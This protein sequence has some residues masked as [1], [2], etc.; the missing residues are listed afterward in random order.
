MQQISSPQMT[1]TKTT[2]TTT[3][4]R[5]HQQ[6]HL[7]QPQPLQTHQPQ[8]QQQRPPTRDVVQ[9]VVQSAQ[10]GFFDSSDNDTSNHPHEDEDTS[11]SS[12][13]VVSRPPSLSAASLT[14]MPRAPAMFMMSVHCDES[15]ATA[16]PPSLPSPLQQQQ[17]QQPTAPTP[18]QQHHHHR[19]QRRESFRPP[20]LSPVTPITPMASCRMPMCMEQH[21]QGA[22]T[23]GSRFCRW[24]VEAYSKYFEVGFDTV[25]EEDDDDDD[26]NTILGTA[27]TSATTTPRHRQQ[28]QHHHYWND[29]GTDSSDATR[30]STMS[31]MTM[32]LQSHLDLTAARRSRSVFVRHHRRDLPADTSKELT[33]LAVLLVMVFIVCVQRA[34]SPLYSD[35]RR[36][37]CDWTDGMCLP[38]MLDVALVVY[39]V[40][41]LG[42]VV[43]WRRRERVVLGRV[44]WYGT[45]IVVGS[46]H[47]WFMAYYLGPQT[48][49]HEMLPL[50]GVILCMFM[51]VPAYVWCSITLAV[52][53]GIV[54]RA[55]GQA[56]GSVEDALFSVWRDGASSP[57][58]T[59]R[60]FT[61]IFW[62]ELYYIVVVVTFAFVTSVVKKTHAN[63]ARTLLHIEGAAVYAHRLELDTAARF[64]ESAI[65]AADEQ[66]AKEVHVDT[67]LRVRDVFVRVAP[68]VAFVPHSVHR[69]AALNDTKKPAW[70]DE[71]ESEDDTSHFRDLKDV[72]GSEL[73]SARAM[74]SY[75][76]EGNDSSR[77]SLDEGLASSICSST[78]VGS[79]KGRRRV[80]LRQGAALRGA[81]PGVDGTLNHS[82]SGHSLNNNN[83]NMNIQL[84]STPRS[85]GPLLPPTP[86]K[87]F[88]AF[89]LGGGLAPHQRPIVSSEPIPT[90]FVQLKPGFRP[91]L[92][93]ALQTN[94]LSGPC[95]MA[96]DGDVGIV[97]PTPFINTI[98]LL[99]AR[100]R[101][102]V[103][104]YHA[105][106]LLATWT[107]SK[108]ITN[109]CEI[110]C[111]AAIDIVRSTDLPPSTLRIG[112]DRSHIVS[113]TVG[114]PQL[115]MFRELRGP[116]VEGA[117]ALTALCEQLD[118]SILISEEV[119]RLLDSA[120]GA[121]AAGHAGGLGTQVSMQSSP[122]P[123]TPQSI[124]AS[125]TGTMAL[126]A[127]GPMCLSIT[128]TAD[129]IAGV[130][131]AVA[132]CSAGSVSR[133]WIGYTT[134][135]DVAAT[136]PPR[137]GYSGVAIHDV[138]LESTSFGSA[139]AQ[140]AEWSFERG[141][142][143]FCS[144]NI[145]GARDAFCEVLVRDPTDRVAKAY[146]RT[147]S[148]LEG[149]VPPRSPRVVGGDGDGLPE[150]R[151]IDLAAT[152]MSVMEYD[153]D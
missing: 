18:K 127:V 71:G 109:P 118:T 11:S 56:W 49:R 50:A 92:A 89:A 26:D 95:G 51:Q 33:H 31:S 19:H 75:V 128:S 132:G 77:M 46:L 22:P 70:E 103:H 86:S 74:S 6:Q 25:G 137:L 81:L 68:F 82:G 45:T 39:C 113:G 43:A 142:A 114:S 1:T 97:D 148:L 5:K 24:I 87:E 125:E 98:A 54:L 13:S 105:G 65:L 85:P 83:N 106:M 58:T 20:P 152:Y 90:P 44:P 7:F 141:I 53:F 38:V 129:D 52:G 130:L 76:G 12:V 42:L 66:L 21:I 30:R 2:T 79:P 134:S 153:E 93:V 136:G 73:C 27:T 117:I 32:S 84:P 63:I 40:G 59:S 4:S 10:D 61:E 149:V 47:S 121:T 112:I 99:I 67:L 126:D 17:Q 116:A 88:L 123:E 9:A 146:L 36:K 138:R 41:S 135:L 94:I 55:A 144:R 133:R 110:A 108:T 35:D 124:T 8:Q 131:R 72:P 107:R 64:L 14:S 16:T 147:I 139:A 60:G 115:R 15:Q 101:G 140:T 37:G 104:S 91:V 120:G 34:L 80:S 23:W 57:E 28:Q 119:S 29:S 150:V 143:L 102:I 48:T 3:T 69:A 96:A 78:Q 122:D 100:H 111:E 62:Y 151:A 145:A